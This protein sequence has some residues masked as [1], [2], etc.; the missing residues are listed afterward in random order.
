MLLSAW[1]TCFATFEDKDPK[2]QQSVLYR[3]VACIISF[4]F[5][6]TVRF[7]VEGGIIARPIARPV[8]RLVMPL[9][10]NS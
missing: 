5:L 4:P 3:T 6:L 2:Q 7:H 1:R 10:A 9:H 8:R